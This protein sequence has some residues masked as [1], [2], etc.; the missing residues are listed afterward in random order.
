MKILVISALPYDIS[1]T[2]RAFDT[3]FSFV[4]K[5]DLAQIFTNPSYPSF[6]RCSNYFQITD[7]NVIKS[8]FNKRKEVGIVLDA[9][10]IE[11]PLPAN[12]NKT[13][14]L[15]LFLKKDLGILHLI[16]AS[17]WNKKRWYSVRLQQWLKDFSPDLIFYHNSNSIFLTNMALTLQKELNIPLVTEISDDYYFCKKNPFSIYNS[18]YK[19][20]TRHLLNQ[21]NGIIFISEK[22]KN[23]Y[24]VFNLNNSDYVHICSSEEYVNNCNYQDKMICFYGNIGLNRYKTIRLFA[25]YLYRENIGS[26]DIYCPRLGNSDL[27]KIEKVN[28]INYCGSLD[29]K[30]LMKAIMSYK[31]VLIAEPLDKKTANYIAL[32]LS[33]KISDSL[34]LAKP[35]VAIGRS[36]C[37]TIDFLTTHKCAI[38]INN[39]SDFPKFNKFLDD[40]LLQNKI[41]DNAIQVYKEEFSFEKNAKKAYNILEKACSD[42]YVNEE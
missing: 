2:T 24:S 31:M 4:K 21:S 10:N 30:K 14:G 28:G 6:D 25:K 1:S 23:R 9:N 37:G 33:T 39:P 35:I 7:K 17:I 36:G 22:M 13:N 8:F 34:L 38:V 16:R 5:E 40:T 19:K 11:K 27:S 32:S 15:S 41:K 3:Y 20:R 12:N 18:I 42:Y 26:I 29:Y